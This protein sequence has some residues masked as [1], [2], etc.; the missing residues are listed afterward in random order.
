MSYLLEFGINTSLLRIQEQSLYICCEC[1]NIPEWHMGNKYISEEQSRNPGG[2]HVVICGME[3]YI[4][5]WW[6]LERRI[7]MSRWQ[8]TKRSMN[9]EVIQKEIFFMRYFKRFIFV[10]SGWDH[11]NVLFLF[12]LLWAFVSKMGGLA[13]EGRDRLRY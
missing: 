8:Q 13:I 10:F 11:R 2:M 12:N 4:Y 7:G 6:E 3:W 1:H 5:I 9:Q